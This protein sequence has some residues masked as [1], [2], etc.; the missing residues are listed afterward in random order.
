[1][2][3]TRRGKR[4]KPSR[5]NVLKKNSQGVDSFLE[6]GEEKLKFFIQK[7]MKPTDNSLH[8]DMDYQKIY[9][10]LTEEQ[11][12]NLID[13]TANQILYAHSS[14]VSRVLSNLSLI[15]VDFSQK[16]EVSLRR[17]L[18]NRGA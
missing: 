17:M 8:I 11:Q 1:M 9:E 16:T 13:K 7:I 4:Q 6:N 18:L 12:K 2:I 15:S 5:V 10:H 3:V 14:V